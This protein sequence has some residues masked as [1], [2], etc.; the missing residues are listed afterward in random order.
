MMSAI[1]R[2][3]R[4]VADLALSL[5]IALARSEKGRFVVRY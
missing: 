4:P 5:E 1:E 2:R 3:S